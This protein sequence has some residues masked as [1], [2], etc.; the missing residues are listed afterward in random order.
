MG[1]FP[2]CGRRPSVLLESYSGCESED[3]YDAWSAD[4]P[5]LDPHP[6]VSGYG[7]RTCCQKIGE[8]DHPPAGYRLATTADA[9]AYPEVAS[10]MNAWDICRL[11]DGWIDGHGYGNKIG[12]AIQPTAAFPLQANS[13][14]VM[15]HEA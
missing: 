3:E 7:T 8:W 6:T 12:C 1:W 2:F 15:A 11:A 10:C 13:G 5:H 4:E 9:R 14:T